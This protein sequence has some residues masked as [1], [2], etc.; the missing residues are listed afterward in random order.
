[1][2]ALALSVLIIV[3]GLATV[4]ARGGLPL[5]V[6]FTGGTVIIVQFQ[7]P[8][9]EDAVRDAL[10]SQASEAVVQRFGPASQNQIMVRLPLRDESGQE[11]LDAAARELEASLRASE[12]NSTVA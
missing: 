4:V 1:W 7:Q 5:G 8:V 12:L 10:G 11:A 6:D 3:A 2:H 9:S